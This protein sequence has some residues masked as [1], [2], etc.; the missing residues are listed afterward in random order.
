MSDN[1][2]IQQAEAVV[3]ANLDLQRELVD[4]CKRGD[5]S[6]VKDFIVRGVDPH[7]GNKETALRVACRYGVCIYLY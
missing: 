3:K 7:C 4:V 6:V 5:L 2:S 1:V